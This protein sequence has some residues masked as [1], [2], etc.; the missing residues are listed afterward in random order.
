MSFF[1]QRITDDTFAQLINAAN[2]Y[3]D[4]ANPYVE[5][6]RKLQS[7]FNSPTGD[8]NQAK[9]LAAELRSKGAALRST[10]PAA[11]PESRP[12]TPAVPGADVKPEDVPVPPTAP[13]V[14]TATEAGVDFKP[15]DVP[16][17]APAEAPVPGEVNPFVPP[18]AEAP[19]PAP[20]P[21]AGEVNPFAPA[22]TPPAPE[23]KGFF[24]SLKSKF[25][26]SSTPTASTGEKTGFFSSLKNR[27]SRKKGGKHVTPRRRSRKQ[28]SKKKQNNRK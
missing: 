20:A 2:V 9:A 26:R 23:K 25:S 27:F 4:T 13:G 16:A 8:A 10:V 17:P 7:L 22:G 21:A 15:E 19:A 3:K 24:S 12:A 5:T 11:Q 18:P 28:L 14:W 6:V 1:S